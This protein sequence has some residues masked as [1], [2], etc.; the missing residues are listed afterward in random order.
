[1]LCLSQKKSFTKKSFTKKEL[2][3]KRA[4]QKQ[5][6]MLFFAFFVVSMYYTN[7]CIDYKF[8]NAIWFLIK[9]MLN[10][11]LCYV[12]GLDKNWNFCQ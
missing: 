12:T 2:Y 9:R 7:V 8:T 5:K 3:K 1:M 4:L 10:V 6:Y 11:M